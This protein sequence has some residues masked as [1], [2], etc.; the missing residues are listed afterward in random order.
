M[1]IKR[2]PDGSVEALEW[3]NSLVTE[4]FNFGNLIKNIRK[5]EYEDM[6]QREFAEKVLG[7]SATHLSGIEH[8]RKPVSLK[9]AIQFAIKLKQSKRFFVA[10]V[11]QDMLKQN[12]LEYEFTLEPE[13]CPK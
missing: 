2:Y 12:D 7:V 13:G 11:I 5:T 8:N 10:I 1:S 3:L 4:E 6:T 9:K